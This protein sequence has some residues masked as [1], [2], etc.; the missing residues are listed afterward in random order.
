MDDEFDIYEELQL[1]ALTAAADS[2]ALEEDGASGTEGDETPGGSKVGGGEKS[3]PTTPVTPS[4]PPVVTPPATTAKKVP[5][6]TA[7]V[8]VA[9]IAS[10]GKPVVSSAIIILM[11]DW[12]WAVVI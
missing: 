2:N 1:D 12:C 7:A 8:G 3:S 4:P 5:A 6:V 11:L 9:S 10:I